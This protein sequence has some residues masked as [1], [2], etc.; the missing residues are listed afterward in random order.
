MNQLQQMIA[1][2]KLNVLTVDRV[3]E[4]F[5]SIVYKITLMNHQIVY[6]KIPYSQVELRREYVLLKYL[7]EELPVPQ[8]LDYWEGDDRYFGG[9]LLSAVAGVPHTG[10]VDE[11]LAYEIGMYHAKLHKVTL[12]APYLDAYV[13]NAFEKWTQFV[14]NQFYAYA[15]DVNKVIPLK[16][17]EQSLQYFER[18]Q[19]RLPPPD[20]PCLIHMDYRLG[21]ILV[22]ENRVK[23]IID[24]ESVLI[25]ATEM[26]FIKLEHDIFR[27]YIGVKD[28]YQQ[29]YASIRPLI[30]LDQILPFY[31]FTN[32]FNS[33]GWCVRR[34]INKHQAYYQKNLADL[35]V[36]IQV[37][38]F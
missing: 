17:F 3:P 15:Q 34:G 18:Y 26:D 6:I 11:P 28:A 12:D 14:R 22:D 33:I 4:S 29:G 37:D 32:A 23:G 20:G 24:F 27:K 36:I 10:A 8:V 31:A 13:D 7:Y 1:Q 30:D 35:K 21:N 19:K 2:F 9:L 25:G 38:A 16:L 5:S